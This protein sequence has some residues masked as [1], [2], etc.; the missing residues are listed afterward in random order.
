MASDLKVKCHI[1]YDERDYGL[2]FQVESEL[3][4]D[5]PERVSSRLDAYFSTLK[6]S[7]M[8]LIT[9]QELH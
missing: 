2:A 4:A 7:I 3:I 6:V 9:G 5:S 1:E 8:R